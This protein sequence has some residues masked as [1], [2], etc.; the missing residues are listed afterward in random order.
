LGLSTSASNL[1]WKLGTTLWVVACGGVALLHSTAS[2]IVTTMIGDGLCHD[3]Q[4]EQGLENWMGYR[5]SK[6]KGNRSG[7]V[8]AFKYKIN[9][10]IINLSS[11]CALVI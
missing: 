1:R 5:D 6:N 10:F 4:Q 3:P 7:T 2:R 8:G 9:V 11:S